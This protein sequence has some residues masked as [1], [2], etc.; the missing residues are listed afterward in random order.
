MKKKNINRK[1]F[2]DYSSK[3]LD[4]ERS[5]FHLLLYGLISLIIIF[6]IVYSIVNGEIALPRRFGSTIYM[7]GIATYT[8]FFSLILMI[9]GFYLPVLEFYSRRNNFHKRN[10]IGKKYFKYKKWT[11]YLAW[12]LFI[13]SIIIGLLNHNISN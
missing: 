3:I 10:L 12:T 6:Y 8:I 4:Y 13:L 5:K 7:D 11:K 1:I 2:G 9:L